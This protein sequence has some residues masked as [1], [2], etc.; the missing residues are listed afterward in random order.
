MRVFSGLAAMGDGATV[1]HQQVSRFEQGDRVAPNG[2]SFLVGARL[3]FLDSLVGHLAAEGIPQGVGGGIDDGYH[4]LLEQ[5]AGLNGRWR[6]MACCY[7]NA[8]A[9]SVK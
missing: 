4:Q 5:V 1:H 7:V 9:T 3:L 6:G 8:H 2:K